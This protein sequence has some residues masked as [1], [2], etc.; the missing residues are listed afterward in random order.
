MVVETKDGL[1]GYR[2]FPRSSKAEPYGALRSG[3]KDTFRDRLSFCLF[4]EPRCI[5]CHLCPHPSMRT[6]SPFWAFIDSWNSLG[7]S[8]EGSI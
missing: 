3:L 1:I 5:G 7:S 8:E 6:Q 2:V 4:L